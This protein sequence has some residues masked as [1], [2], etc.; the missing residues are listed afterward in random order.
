[1]EPRDSPPGAAPVGPAGDPPGTA[2]PTWGAAL[3]WGT[4]TLTA[5]GSPS[6]QLDALSLL[7]RTLSVPHAIVASMPN[8]PLSH[9][10]THC[11]IDWIWRRAAGEPVAYITGHKA[12]MGLDLYVDR[13]VLLVRRTTELLVEAALEIARLRPATDALLA[14]DIGTGS[15]AIALALACLE[16]R[17]ARVYATDTSA[18]ALAVA[19]HNG[20]RYHLGERVVW[21]EGDLLEP[22]PEPMD[23]VL[24]NL[25]TIP[26]QDVSLAPEVARYEPPV[27][28]WGG[29]DGLALVRRLVRQVPAKLRPGGAVAIEIQPDQGER[30]S[31]LLAAALPAAQVRTVQAGGADRYV[32]AHLGLPGAPI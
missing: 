30:V 2:L 32:I 16:P 3:A 19:R 24:C 13:R 23:L 9:A 15:G 25:P 27:A 17:L 5:A 31:H 1:M 8:R 7:M 20:A 11:Y 14:A 22:V 10:G 29:A 26:E 4:Q 12:F 21:L 6:P 18:D 28:F